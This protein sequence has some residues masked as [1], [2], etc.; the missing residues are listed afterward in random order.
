MLKL[1]NLVISYYFNFS[2]KFDNSY[3]ELKQME[4]HWFNDC[5]II[6]Y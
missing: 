3:F 2:S 1:I 6:T 4:S 5:V